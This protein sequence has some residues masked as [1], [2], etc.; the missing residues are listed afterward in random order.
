MNTS[1]KISQIN[2]QIEKLQAELKEAQEAQ[3]KFLEMPRE[4][5][6]ATILHDKKCQ[7]NHTDGCG[8][9]YEFVNK[10]EQWSAREH[11]NW[12]NKAMA[13]MAACER[14]GITVEKYLEIDELLNG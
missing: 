6:V 12:V 10:Q 7:Y 8:W 3:K 13:L 4:Q 1:D 14:A 2:S 5:Q 11:S 9:Y